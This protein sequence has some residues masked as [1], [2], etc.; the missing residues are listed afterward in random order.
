MGYLVSDSGWPCARQALPAIQYY[1][2]N[3]WVPCPTRAIPM[4]LWCCAMPENIPAPVLCVSYPA[5]IS[6]L[7]KARRP[8]SSQP[9]PEAPLGGMSIRFI[10]RELDID[11]CFPNVETQAGLWPPL[12]LPKKDR[13]KHK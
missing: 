13:Y 4:V 11:F 8:A 10:D 2:T 7:V 9:S 1:Y 6:M 12:P 3:P 5:P